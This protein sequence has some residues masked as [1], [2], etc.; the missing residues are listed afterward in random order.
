VKPDERHLLM[1]VAEGRAK[2]RNVGEAAGMPYKRVCYLCEKWAGKGWY[3]Y[4]V[5]VDLGWLTEAGLAAAKKL[6]EKGEAG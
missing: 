3:D 6:R 4:G 2:P 5:S 1:T